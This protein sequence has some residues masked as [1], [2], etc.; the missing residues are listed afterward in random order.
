VFG[1][2]PEVFDV[3]TEQQLIADLREAAADAGAGDPIPGASCGR[4]RC[5]APGLARRFLDLH[6]A[7]RAR[8]PAR[9]PAAPGPS[10]LRAR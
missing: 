4:R 2:R 1:V 7:R 6:R 3:D 9:T 5:N 10:T 8:T